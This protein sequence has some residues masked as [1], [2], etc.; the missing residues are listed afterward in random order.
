MIIINNY[1]VNN[2]KTAFTLIELLVAVLLSSLLIGLTASTYSLFRKSISQDQAKADISQNARI[3]MDRLSRELRQTPEVVTELPIDYNDNSVTQP[4][5]IMFEDGHDMGSITYR[6][7]YIVGN[8]LKQDI[9]EY[10]FAAQSDVR[11]KWNDVDASNNLPLSTII[12][13]VDI[14]DNVSSISFYGDNL[15]EA[16]ILTMDGYG[17]QYALRTV[18][19]A[20]NF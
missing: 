18:I 1:K 14:A 11:V 7:Y 16:N 8:V 15:I 10:Y 12:S 13:T 9:I 2:Q 20:R 19:K 17:Q 5:E 6:R 3:V 4:G